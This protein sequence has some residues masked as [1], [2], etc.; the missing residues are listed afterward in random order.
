MYGFENTGLNARLDGGVVT[1]KKDL[2]VLSSFWLERNQE[3]VML[4][5]KMEDIPEHTHLEKWII[6]SHFEQNEF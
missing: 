2:K 4:N 1:K 3:I 6:G 5:I